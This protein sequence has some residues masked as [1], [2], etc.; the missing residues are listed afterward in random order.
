MKIA[1]IGYGK[2][3]KPLNVLHL[4]G[5]IKLYPSLT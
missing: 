5:D 1:L 4:N 3:E 2:M